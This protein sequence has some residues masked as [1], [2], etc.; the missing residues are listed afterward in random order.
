MEN[1]NMEALHL[2]PCWPFWGLLKAVEKPSYSRGGFVEISSILH[3][4]KNDFFNRFWL[5]GMQ[6]LAL[7]K[8]RTIEEISSAAK[9]IHSE[10]FDYTDQYIKQETERYVQQLANSSG[11]ELGYLPEGSRG[12]E[13]EIRYLLNNWSSE[14]DDR[15]DFPSRDDINDLEALAD[16]LQFDNFDVSNFIHFG[17]VEP[18]EH[19]FYAVLTLMIICESFHSNSFD[20]PVNHYQFEPTVSQVKAIGIASIQAVEAFAYADKIQV[21]EKIKKA[22]ASAQP[23]M[24]AAALQAQISDRASKAAQ[25]RH[26]KNDAARNFVISEWQRNCGAYDGNKTAFTRDYVRRVSNE[27]NAQVTEKTMREV[28]LKNTLSAGKQAG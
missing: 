10:I 27:F 3:Y 9:E 17:L 5:V 15:P 26:A 18:E 6:A 13:D 24:L 25:K 16:S 14:W 19:E 4:P 28:W 7:L 20:R 11:W 21:I 8:R 1:E 22:I 2:E 12:T 23:A